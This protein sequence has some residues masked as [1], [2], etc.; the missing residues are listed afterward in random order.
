MS[1]ELTVG[2]HYLLWLSKG[3]YSVC[4]SYAAFHRTASP[5]LIS[6]RHSGYYQTISC[7]T[8]LTILLNW[9]L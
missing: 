9:R 8:T 2:L 7:R 3:T 1:A 6:P 5:H 4:Q